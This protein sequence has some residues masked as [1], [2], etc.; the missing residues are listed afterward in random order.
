MNISGKII[1]LIFQTFQ[2]FDF[3]VEHIDSEFSF[4][5]SSDRAF[6]QGITERELKQEEL[7]QQDL[8]WIPSKPGT[9]SLK[10]YTTNFQLDGETQRQET[11]PL[12]LKVRGFEN[13]Y[14][15]V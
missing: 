14:G 3:S 11:R 13:C 7:I 1:T 12:T 2:I 5:W 8:E 4:V 10:G 9:Y 15:W 6:L